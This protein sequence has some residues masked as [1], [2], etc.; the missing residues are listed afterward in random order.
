MTIPNYFTDKSRLTNRK[1]HAKNLYIPIIY[2]FEAGETI[3]VNASLLSVLV[4]DNL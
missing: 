3:A 1:I 4:Y 2:L